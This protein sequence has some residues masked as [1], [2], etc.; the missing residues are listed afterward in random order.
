[1]LYTADPVLPDQAGRPRH[2]LPDPDLRLVVAPRPVDSQRV[3]LGDRP[4]PGRDVMHDWFSK[5]G[6]GVGSEYRYNFGAGRTATS[7]PTARPAEA[8]YTQDDGTSRHADASRSYEHP[9]RRQPAAAGRSARARRTSTTSPASRRSQTFNTN[10]YDASRNSRIFG[11]NVVGAWG[12]VLA[13]RHLRSQR[14]LLRH[15]RLASLPGSWPRVALHAQ[16][17][18]DPRTR[19]LYFSL[20]GEYVQLCCDRQRIT[21]TPDI[22]TSMTPA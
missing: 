9:R 1:M 8:T 15:D 14:V 12:N 13:E 20:G 6:Q 18:A 16:R 7:A 10:I 17:A 22:D 19:R 21:T 5:T 2:R 4:Q 11:G 3:L